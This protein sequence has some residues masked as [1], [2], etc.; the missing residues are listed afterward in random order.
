MF[1]LK[2]FR[3]QKFLCD[4]SCVSSNVNSDAFCGGVGIAKI[5]VMMVM[6]FGGHHVVGLSCSVGPSVMLTLWL[7]GTWVSVTLTVLVVLLG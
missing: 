2:R 6:M 3:T 5:L 4:A 7:R 1:L